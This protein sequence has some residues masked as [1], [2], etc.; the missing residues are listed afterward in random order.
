MFGFTLLGLDGTL[1][2]VGGFYLQTLSGLT[3]IGQRG[4]IS[5]LYKVFPNELA[6]AGF[7]S[8]IYVMKTK[9]FGLHFKSGFVVV[10]INIFILQAFKIP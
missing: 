1:R 2:R 9:M 8:D 3:Q 7:L 5:P 6:I 4:E 10:S